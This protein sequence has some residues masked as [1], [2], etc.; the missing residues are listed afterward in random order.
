MTKAINLAKEEIRL[1]RKRFELLQHK[2]VTTNQRKRF[3]KLKELSEIKK[4]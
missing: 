3:L 1:G 4:P 2:T